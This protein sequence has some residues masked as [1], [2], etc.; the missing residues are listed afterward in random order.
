MIRNLACV[1]GEL[2]VFYELQNSV[3]SRVLFTDGFTHQGERSVAIYEGNA[4]IVVF[5]HSSQV[6]Y[7]LSCHRNHS[8]LRGRRTANPAVLDPDPTSRYAKRRRTS[9]ATTTCRAKA[10]GSYQRHRQLDS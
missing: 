8:K 2:S 6:Q 10:C 5:F 1:L 4:A 9:A 7:I 3:L